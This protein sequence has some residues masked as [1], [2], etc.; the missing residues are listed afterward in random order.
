M[1]ENFK[2]QWQG[3]LAINPPLELI[4]VK[5]EKRIDLLV[6]TSQRFDPTLVFL[7]MD[8]KDLVRYLESNIVKK[9]PKP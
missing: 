3:F 8:F 2:I 1:K 4:L 9:T 6:S 5:M 7:R